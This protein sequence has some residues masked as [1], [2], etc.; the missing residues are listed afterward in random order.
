[1]SLITRTRLKIPRS[2]RQVEVDVK[3]K[4]KQKWEESEE[5]RTNPFM[6]HSVWPVAR[7]AK[8]KMVPHNAPHRA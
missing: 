5:G 6:D 2:K 1:M 4:V 3:V 8:R 7:L